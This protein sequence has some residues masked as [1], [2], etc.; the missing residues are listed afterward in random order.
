LEKILNTGII[1]PV[2]Y[3]EWVSNLIPV[4][5]TT[6]HIIFCVDFHAV[7]QAIMKGYSPLPNT[8]NILQQV[9][10]S[11]MMPLLNVFSNYNL[12]KVRGAGA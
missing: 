1:F 7:K 6:E 12:I 11:Q 8:E 5:K 3:F 4:Q 10:G 9:A 2:K